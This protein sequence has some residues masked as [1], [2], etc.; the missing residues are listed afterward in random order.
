MQGLVEIEVFGTRNQESRIKN[1]EPGHKT[2]DVGHRTNDIKCYEVRVRG[3]TWNYA[4][5][6]LVNNFPKRAMFR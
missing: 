4:G 5:N 2:E 1:Q 6:V 3:F